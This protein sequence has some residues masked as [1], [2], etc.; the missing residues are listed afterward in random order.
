M[1]IESHGL[2]NDEDWTPETLAERLPAF[3]Y[4]P[5]KFEGMRLPPLMA[6]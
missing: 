6:R 4:Q 5:P 2:A 1:Y 3:L